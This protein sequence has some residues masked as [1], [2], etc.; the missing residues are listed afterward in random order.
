MGDSDGGNTTV[1]MWH[2]LTMPTDSEVLARK[3]GPLINNDHS[4]HVSAKQIR[5]GEHS[6]SDPVLH[7]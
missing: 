2:I 4:T 5:P 3:P 6:V 1:L 7:H